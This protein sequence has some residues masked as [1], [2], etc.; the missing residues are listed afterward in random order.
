MWNVFTLQKFTKLR[1]SKIPCT[2]FSQNRKIQ[3]MFHTSAKLTTY[4]VY[5]NL[6]RSKKGWWK[7]TKGR[8]WIHWLSDLNCP[9]FK[10]QNT[11]INIYMKKN[12]YFQLKNTLIHLVNIQQTKLLPPV[13]LELNVNKQMD[14]FSISPLINLTEEGKKLLAVSNFEVTDS[15]FNIT[16][17]NHSFS[18]TTPGHW[19][20]PGSVNK[21]IEDLELWSQSFFKLHVEEIE[22]RRQL[23]DTN[24]Q[25]SL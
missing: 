7:Y 4:K 3:K 11:Y 17:E 6:Q 8:N 16:D 24:I 5:I 10:I 19:S 18:I 9:H 12:C 20:D 13:T 2:E 1:F 15:V 23:I 25:K 14:A 22:W 21:L